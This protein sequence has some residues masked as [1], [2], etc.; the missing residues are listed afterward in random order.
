MAPYRN[1][2]SFLCNLRGPTVLSSPPWLL[3]APN[4]KST[5]WGLLAIKEVLK[6]S[7]SFPPFPKE[8]HVCKACICTPGVVPGWVECQDPQGGQQQGVPPSPGDTESTGAGLV[9]GALASVLPF[10]FLFSLLLD[11]LN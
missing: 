9:V 11:F 2:I 8:L 5:P 3:F 10:L 4:L 1:S 6:P 7:L